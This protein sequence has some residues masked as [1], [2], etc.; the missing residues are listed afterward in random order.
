MYREALERTAR[1]VHLVHLV[2]VDSVRRTYL[3]TYHINLII[4]PAGSTTLN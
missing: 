4:Q 2:V 3:L 1:S